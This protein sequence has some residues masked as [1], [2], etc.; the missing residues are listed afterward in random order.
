LADLLLDHPA[1][2]RRLAWR[3]CDAFLGEDVA[4]ETAIAELAAQLQKDN[5]HIGNAVATVLRSELF[6]SQR[7]LHARVCDPETFIV[8]AVRA[9]E[10]F[11]PP[12]ST[13]LLA[14]WCDRLGH[15]LFFPP[16]VG[17]WR[18]GRSWLS[19]RSIIARANYAAAI[20]AGGL[21]AG[22]KAPDLSE[23]SERNA[24]SRSAEQAIVFFNDLLTGGQL[25]EA[26]RNEILDA[27]RANENPNQQPLTHAVAQLLAR[28]EAQLT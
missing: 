7:N 11:R 22:A 6:F 12:P 16:N 19:A 9:I 13:L 27:A 3:L 23:L 26:E 15:E 20:A 21:T 24:R 17:G 10:Q 8:S 18:G 1:T 2:A 25:G 14:E 28:P 5:L 4:D